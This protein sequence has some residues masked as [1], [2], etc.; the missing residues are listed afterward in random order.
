M[1]DIMKIVGQKRNY[2]YQIDMFKIINK[3]Q[4]A[5]INYIK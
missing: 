2:E 3:S 4:G 5:L 1:L